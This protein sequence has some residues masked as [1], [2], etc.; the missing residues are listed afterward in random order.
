MSLEALN[1]LAAAQARLVA[2]LDGGDIAGIEA[3]SQALA[4]EVEQVRSVAAWRATP[5]L[6]QQAT[7]AMQIGESARLRLSYHADRGRRR[8]EVLLGL[9]GRAAANYGRNG[10]MR[11]P[12]G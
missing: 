12:G 10:R 9:A 3:A 7:G 2:A 6:Q 8:L 4:R 11:L 5:E 1:A